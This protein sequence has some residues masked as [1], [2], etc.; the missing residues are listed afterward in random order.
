MFIRVVPISLSIYPPR[1][2]LWLIRSFF[3]AILILIPL[4]LHISFLV[5]ILKV[6][7]KFWVLHSLI[8]KGISSSKFLLSP[9][10]ITNIWRR[11]HNSNY[12]NTSAIHLS[13]IFLEITRIRTIIREMPTRYAVSFSD[14]PIVAFTN[15]HICQELSISFQYKHTI[16]NHLFIS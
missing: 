7:H 3:R 16:Y 13:L 11:N 12:L 1:Y 10:Q 6:T 2:F 5:L 4:K 15:C 14:F 8:L 9:S